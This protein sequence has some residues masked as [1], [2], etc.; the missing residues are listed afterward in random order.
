MPQGRRKA[1]EQLAGTRC[2]HCGRAL[3]FG[4]RDGA[5]VDDPLCPVCGRGREDEVR[6]LAAAQGLALKTLQGALEDL[7]ANNARRAQTRVR[8]AMRRLQRALAVGDDG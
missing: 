7:S 2:A 1:V 8:S 6:E 3:V 5:R 4:F